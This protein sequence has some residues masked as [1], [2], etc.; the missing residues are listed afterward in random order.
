[1]PTSTTP[2]ATEAIAA[3]L[4]QRRYE[5]ARRL[6]VRALDEADGD[7]DAVRL[8]LHDALQHLGDI[9]AARR[10]ILG[11]ATLPDTCRGQTRLA[12]DCYRLT[13]NNAYRT[14]AEQRQGL[15]LEQYIDKYDALATEGFAAAT[16]LVRD[17]DDRHELAA[18]LRR[19]KRRDAADAICPPPEA[20]PP[21]ARPPGAW[22]GSGAEAEL[23]RGSLS[24]RLWFEDGSPV[25]D[26]TVTLGLAVPEARTD[27]AT[28]LGTGMHFKGKPTSRPEVLRAEVNADGHYRIAAVPAGRCAFLSVTLDPG[29][30]AVHTRF[31]AQ[32][33]EVPAGGDKILNA[34]V[35][36]WQS[37]PPT[38]RPNPHPPRRVWRGTTLRKVHGVALANPFHFDFPTQPLRIELP[39]DVNAD[40]TRLI[41]FADE[42]PDAPVPWQRDGNAVVFMAD[43]PGLS[44]AAPGERVLHRS[45]ALYEMDTP[46]TAASDDAQAW[47]TERGADSVVLDTGVAQ[48]RLPLGRGT[49]ATP[50]LQGVRG[51]DHVWR[52]TGRWVLPEGIDIATW[53]S[54]CV[55]R[56]PV[57]CELQLDYRFTTGQAYTWRVRAYRGEETLLVDETSCDVPGAA[58]EFSLREFDGGRGYLHWTPEDGSHHWSDLAAD[59]REL[60]RLQESVPWWIPPSGFAYAMTDGTLDGEDY[61]AVF[62]MR[63][64]EWIDRLFGSVA[65]GPG[66]D[67]REWDWPYPEMV[68]ST[69][70]MI[71]ARSDATGDHFFRF[72]C[73]DGRR[74]WGLMA[75]AFGDND[76][77]HKRLSQTQHKYSSPRLQDFMHWRLDE[78][79]HHP[80][81]S[82]VATRDDLPALKR[83][84]DDPRFTPLY[85]RMKRN[86]YPHGKAGRGLTAL[87]EGDPV[88]LWMLKQEIVAEAPVR[89]RMTLLGRDYG[90]MY[91]PVGARPITP[92]VENYDLIAATGVFDA[93]EERLCRAFFLLMGHLYM[94]E[95]LMNWRF[96]SRNANFEADRVDVVGA[97][98]LAF[99]GNPDA[100]AMIGHAASLME[101]S[102]DVYCTP[103]SGKWY[104]NPACYYLHAGSCRLNLAW[105]LHR[106]DILDCTAIPRLKDFLAWGPNLL[107]PAMPTGYDLLR[108]GC[109]AAG[110]DAAERVRRIPPIG[111]HAHLGQWV[112]EF[113]ALFAKVYHDADPALAQRLRWAYHAGGRDGGHF[114]NYPLYFVHADASDLETPPPVTPVS[115]RL[116]GFG[117]VFRGGVN[118][119][120][121]FYCLFKLGPGGYRYHRTEGSII[122]FADGKPLI[123][124]GG[125]GGETWRHTTLSFGETHAPLAAGHI[126]RFASFDAVDF[127]QGVNPKALEAGEPI[128]LSD[129]CEHHLVEEARR[130]FHEPRP[131]NSRSCLWVKDE[132]LLLHDQLDLPAGLTT[133]WHLQAVADD[134]A[135]T[136]RDGWRFKG[137]L[138]TDFQV[139]LPGQAFDGVSFTQTPILDHQRGPAAAFTMRHM[140]AT[141]VSPDHRLAVIR[142]LHGGRG[143]L[144]SACE[145]LDRGGVV[146]RVRG[147]GIDD[148]HALDRHGTMCDD[149][150]VGFDGRYA[151]VLR[152][153]STRTLQLLDGS[154]LALDGV[155]IHARGVRVGL[156]YDIDSSAFTLEA[157]GRG[158]LRVEGLDRPLDLTLTP[159]DGRLRMTRS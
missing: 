89:S 85:E 96:N 159:D 41:L 105:H 150:G 142:P 12:E 92:W 36:A 122:L 5:T 124:D 45:Y 58:F 128:F 158:E 104:E 69:V 63:R 9:P 103:G 81:P 138:G 67:R 79:D 73:F 98:G 4:A 131:A 40:P 38:E 3:S 102:L 10:A 88:E 70:S 120:E 14:S 31:L 1:M 155:T 33:I 135:E 118:T 86:P 152:R 52:G 141:A 151:S 115:R 82:V 7:D 139:A 132:Y 42:A 2:S 57:F 149:G 24:G 111:D 143:E 77:P 20:M 95:D 110:Y 15:T 71:T 28:Y 97:V 49:G 112:G 68:G 59:D 99:R 144:V 109:D 93:D 50:P 18:A 75:S 107:T 51:P 147:D 106:H 21:E 123:Y 37:A 145:S 117:A 29:A 119:P 94:Q 46:P 47:L 74:K 55:A 39:P 157:E 17:D 153:G 87:L 60:A 129:S 121:E 140:Q 22:P 80:R 156:T 137:R 113:T 127:A 126:E 48:F 148:W 35:A 83:K 32:G 30:H 26:A 8:L 27:P 134:H 76:G 13:V 66:D 133:H 146:V 90:D 11:S 78:A 25:T 114:N 65:Q 91:S 6:A 23:R 16:A 101:S 43:L 53:S 56:G 154:R 130:R 62:T 19:C 108:D 54:E 125:E 136:D 61:L 84:K 100:E 64:G 34:E 116:A 44:D 72:A